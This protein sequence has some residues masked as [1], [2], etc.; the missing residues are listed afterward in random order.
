MAESQTTGSDASDK[1]QKP[2]GF[3]PGDDILTHFRNIYAGVTGKMT[4][5]GVEQFR[6]ARDLRNEE[7]DCRRCESQRDYL[8]NYSMSSYTPSSPVL[9]DL[10]LIWFIYLIG[11]VIRFLQDN[12]RQLGGDISSKNI[13]CRRCTARQGGG[14][15]PEYG[16][17]ICANAMN[18]QSQ[19]EDTLAHEMVHAYDHLRFKLDWTNNLRHAACAEIRASSLSGECRWANEFF[20]R[21]EFKLANHHQECVRRRAVMSVQARPACKSKEQAL[22]V[23]DEVW[24]SCFRDTRPFDEIYR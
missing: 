16:I 18:S 7:S 9:L 21:F 8:L 19:L 12:I 6:L 2:T 11:P 24:E 14:F 1:G 10:L 13:Y 22:R 3:K 23:V 17:Q 4:P 15:D 5:E 20:G